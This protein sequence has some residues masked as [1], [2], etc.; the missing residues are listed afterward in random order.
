MSWHGDWWSSHWWSGQWRQDWSWQESGSSGSSGS[1]WQEAGLTAPAK[2]A[3]APQWQ[4]KA[5]Q[6]VAE[7]G[8]EVEPPTLQ[9]IA[10]T[11]FSDKRTAEAKKRAGSG[12]GGSQYGFVATTE[13][14]AD[15]KFDPPMFCWRVLIFADLAKIPS[16]WWKDLISSFSDMY[17]VTIS[18]RKMRHALARG[19]ESRVPYQITVR[20]LEVAVAFEH[21]LDRLVSECSNVV[22]ISDIQGYPLPEMKV[23]LEAPDGHGGEWV[24]TKVEEGVQRFQVDYMRRT[25][26]R[27]ASDGPP[28]RALKPTDTKGDPGLQ[29]GGSFWKFTEGE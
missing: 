3:R 14:E 4:Q 27:D 12:A 5:L 26:R 11:S 29:A 2:R 21:V 18:R 22:D 25:A 13:S 15:E 24:I 10:R 17:G 6:T 20:G 16:M 8:T 9:E 19:A 28:S 23:G 1:G 7:E